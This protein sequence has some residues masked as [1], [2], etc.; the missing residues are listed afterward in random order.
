MEIIVLLDTV[1]SDLHTEKIEHKEEVDK[2]N[3]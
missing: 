1:E 2:L 3:S